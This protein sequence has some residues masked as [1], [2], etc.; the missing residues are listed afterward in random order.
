MPKPGT[1]K[2]RLVIYCRYVN[3]QLRGCEFPL[4]IIEDL[5]VK[6]AGNHRWTLPILEDGFQQ[7]PLSECSRQYTAFCSSFWGI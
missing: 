7:M 5:F 2:W 1:N 4:L 3:T 6:Q